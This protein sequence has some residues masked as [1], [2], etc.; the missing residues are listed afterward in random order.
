MNRTTLLAK[1]LATL[2]LA[3]T[4]LSTGG[5]QQRP[6]CVASP[7]ALPVRYSLGLFGISA[8]Y[9]EGQPKRRIVDE[10][11]A[12]SNGKTPAPPSYMLIELIPFQW[13]CQ[14]PGD[15][16]IKGTDFVAFVSYVDKGESGPVPERSR[17]PIDCVMRSMEQLARELGASGE[18]EI[19]HWGLL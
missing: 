9:E 17:I 16:R 10:F 13:C 1:A 3:V 5:C 6:A 11:I 15:I 7:E 18:V 12:R 2:L 8:E 4:L 14:R 19:A